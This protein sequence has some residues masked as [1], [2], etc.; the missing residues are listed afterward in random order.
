MAEN[1]TTSIF[2]SGNEFQCAPPRFSPAE[3]R[4]HRA[5]ETRERRIQLTTLF[6]SGL[7]PR[8]PEEHKALRSR[9]EKERMRV[10]SGCVASSIGLLSRFNCARLVMRVH[11]VCL[12]YVRKRSLA[13][14]SHEKM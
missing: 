2:L 6:M 4:E 9:V 7:K 1:M 8:P 14:P 13:A 12:S 11:E 3:K 5:D 10:R